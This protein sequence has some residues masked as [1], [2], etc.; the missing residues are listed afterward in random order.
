MQCGGVLSLLTNELMSFCHIL[1]A[2]TEEAWS[3]YKLTFFHSS[4]ENGKET[5]TNSSDK[6]VDTLP[7]T[8]INLL[9][10]D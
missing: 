9:Y 7:L 1:G 2:L 4:N 3:V 6:S 8:Y 10:D 5:R